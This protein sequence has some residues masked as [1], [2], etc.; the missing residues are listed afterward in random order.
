MATQEFE[1]M[2][3]ERGIP[4]KQ[5]PE[6]LQAFHQAGVVLAFRNVRL[7]SLA[8]VS[9]SGPHALHPMQSSDEDL[10][11]SIFLQPRSVIDSYLESIGLSPVSTQLFTHEREA[12]LRKIRALEPEHVAL[13]NL[14]KELHAAATRHANAIAVGLSTSLVGT[15]GLYFWLSF[16]HFS[17]DIMEPVTYFTGFGMSVVGYAWWSVTNQEYEYENIYDYFYKRKLQKLVTRAHF[18]QPR[19]DAVTKT[20]ARDRA[21]LAR[22]DDALTK[23]TPL[24]ASYLHLLQDANAWWDARSGEAVVATAKPAADAAAPVAPATKQ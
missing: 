24:Q 13:V 22:I 15:F 14:R 8:I 17:W 5:A 2:C 4:K 10:Q 18:D 16:I 7:A 6:V 23:A 19:L 11:G 9:V 20:L 3:K 12:L 1:L 21:Q